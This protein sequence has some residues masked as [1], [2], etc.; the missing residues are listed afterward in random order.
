VW[1]SEE[2]RYKQNPFE[3]ED[4][5]KTIY[6]SEY[7]TP[8]RGTQIMELAG[9][10]A[11]LLNLEYRFPFLLY[12]FP[13]LGVLGQLG[14]VLFID[15]GAVWSNPGGQM[16]GVITYGWGP[17]FIL[18]GLPFQLD[19]ARPYKYYNLPDKDRSRHWY[20]TIGTDF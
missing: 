10:R 8:L 19:F 7:V 1:S 13:A 6:F 12:Y 20:L 5:L 15:A 4:F 3:D 2:L 18:F 16:T 9:N 14:G 11:T 17:R